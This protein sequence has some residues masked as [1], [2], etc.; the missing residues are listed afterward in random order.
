VEKIVECYSGVEYAEQ[1]RRFRWEGGWRT[2]GR[3]LAEC[4]TEDGKQFDLLDDTGERFRLAYQ[5]RADCWSIRPVGD[6]ARG[7][8]FL[9]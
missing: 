1:P 4:R 3:I 9:R 2:V 5:A 6:P 7:D 8:H